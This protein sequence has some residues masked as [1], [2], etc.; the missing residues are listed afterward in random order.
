MEA[1]TR[2]GARWALRMRVTAD[3]S[4]HQ[5]SMLWRGQSPRRQMPLQNSHTFM[6]SLN[7]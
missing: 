4:G 2:T 6:I 5:L 7:L 1:D 3:P